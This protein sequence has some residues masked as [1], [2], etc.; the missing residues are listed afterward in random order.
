V[1]PAVD[2]LVSKDGRINTYLGLSPGEK[3][4]REAGRHKYDPVLSAVLTLKSDNGLHLRLRE[5]RS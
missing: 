2:E 5:R 1:L 4:K 3:L